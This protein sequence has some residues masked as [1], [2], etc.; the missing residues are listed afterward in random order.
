MFATRKKSVSIKCAAVFLAV[1]LLI[2]FVAVIVDRNVNAN[3]VYVNGRTMVLGV[4]QEYEYPVQSE[5][6]VHFKSYNKDVVTVDSNG[7]FKAVA[8]GTALVKVGASKFTVCV[9]DAPTALS[10]SES[11]FSIGTGEKYMPVI[12]VEGSELNTG[13]EF[14]SSDPNVLGVDSAGNIIGVAQGTADL[15][16]KSYNGL[17]AN[18]KVSVLAAPETIQLPSNEKTIYIGTEKYLKPTVPTGSASKMIYIDSDNTQVLKTEG[19]KLIPVSE[20]VAN[21]TAKTYNGKTA[22]CKVTVLNA[23]FYIR[24]D[25]DPSKPMIALSFDDGPNSR[26]TSVILDTLEQNNGSATFFMVANRL[27]HQGNADCAKRMVQLG[28]QL[29]NHTYDHSHYGNDVTAEDIKNG[30]NAIKDATGYYP[31][32]FRPTGGYLSDTIKQN[33]DAPICLW[34]VDTN[35]WKYKNAEKVKNYVLYA[36]DDGDVVLMHDI[37]KTSAEAVQMFVPELVSRGY[38]IVN[39]AELAYYKD[40]DMSNGQ[41]YSSFR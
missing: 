39:I 15:S 38:Q 13:F 31:S 34:N 28:C 10:F 9:E 4:G 21:V 29:G 12:N 22:T 25:L 36:A 3:T 37:Y 23:P 6:I 35:D 2:S 19:S 14:T 20:G 16:V 24:T 7:V 26:T 27:S 30:I 17:S 41:I 11:D 1:L 40:V 5:N 8:K 18:T 32:V 33:A